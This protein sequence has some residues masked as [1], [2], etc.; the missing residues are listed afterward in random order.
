MNSKLI[1][2]ILLLSSACLCV[3]DD[4]DAKNADS[5]RKNNVLKF[6]GYEIVVSSPVE[7]VTMHK[8]VAMKKPEI[9]GMN[10]PEPTEDYRADSV[11][12]GAASAPFAMPVVRRSDDDNESETD[13]WLLP[14][15]SKR[16]GWGW[17]ADGVSAARARETDK[18][19]SIGAILEQ[20]RLMT[21]GP[22]LTDDSGLE[23]MP[24]RRSSGAYRT[25]ILPD[26]TSRRDKWL[27]DR[28][29]K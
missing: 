11:M 25:R 24:R 27:K 22:D 12:G 4:S 13:S 14:K 23:G 5:R 8:P 1:V 28:S 17:L 19:T 10:L 26:S 7:S 9:S 6:K 2:P 3:S 21:L 29:K 15:T 16:S 18:S 20:D